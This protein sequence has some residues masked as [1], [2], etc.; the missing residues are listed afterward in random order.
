MHNN[1]RGDFLTQIQNVLPPI[2]DEQ[3]RVLIVG[4]M[5]GV[6]SLQ[7]QQYYGNERNHFWGIMS[8][9]L[10]VPI[11]ETYEEK[12][13]LL[14]S[15][16]IGLWDVIHSCERKGSLDANIQNE[17]PNDFASLFVQYP[18]I[19]CII[20]NGG[21]AYEVFKKKVGFPLL[22]GK[23]YYKMPSTSPIP[24][25]NIQTFEQKVES[26]RELTKYMK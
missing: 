13:A 16:Q 10:H 4:S 21:K 24:G 22:E 6:Q 5:P 11:P 1:A 8:E 12:I 17:V 3:T 7:K 14:R 25:K 9:L 20:F 26:W 19:L 15:H 18:N 2:V 23:S